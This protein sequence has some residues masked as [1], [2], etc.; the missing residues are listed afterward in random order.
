MLTP[1][2][3]RFKNLC[4]KLGKNN[5]ALYGALTIAASKGILRPTFTMMDK[6]QDKKSRKYTAFLFN[7]TIVFSGK[8]CYDS[9]TTNRCNRR[10]YL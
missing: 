7:F 1:F 9:A 5:N 6:K 8:R 10:N 2:Q 4:L 3:N